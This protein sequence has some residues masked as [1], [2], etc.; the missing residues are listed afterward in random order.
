MPSSLLD[1]PL[2]A[3]PMTPFSELRKRK[4][5]REGGGREGG[6]E[7]GRKGGEREGGTEGGIISQC[8]ILDA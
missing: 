8:V 2:Y 6:R 4:T 5:E 1:P 7:G 3:P